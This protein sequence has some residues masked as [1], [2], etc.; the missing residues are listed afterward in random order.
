[1]EREKIRNVLVQQ[2]DDTKH[3][4]HQQIL[5][6]HK[7]IEDRKEY[8]ERLNSAREEEEAR[9][10]EELARQAALAEQRRLEQEREERERR[11]Q[12]SEKKQIRDRNLKEKM[13]QI[14]QTSHGQKVL[15]KL[16]EDVS[17]VLFFIFM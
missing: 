17:I 7:I 13:Q 14:S 10:Q 1:M 16:D 8:L 9:R 11:R 2:Y 3:K 5:A 12:E 15:K 4:E 6:R